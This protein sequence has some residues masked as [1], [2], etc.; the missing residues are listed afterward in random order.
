MKK[1]AICKKS[2]EK[3]GDFSKKVL[4]GWNS[5]ATSGPWMCPMNMT[6]RANAIPSTSVDQTFA[7]E[8]LSG[9]GRED[10]DVAVRA[11]PGSGHMARI[12]RVMDGNL[13]SNSRSCGVGAAAL[14]LGGLD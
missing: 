12:G 5:S 6:G 1:D 2:D 3:I 14:H 4:P 10:G 7:A 9:K 11:A 13:T 8:V